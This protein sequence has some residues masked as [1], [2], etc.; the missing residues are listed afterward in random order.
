[1][2]YNLPSSAT[3]QHKVISVQRL[4]MPIDVLIIN[5]NTTNNKYNN[6]TNKKIFNVEYPS[7]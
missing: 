5:N 1:M 2:T 4:R 7:R 3:G 6:N